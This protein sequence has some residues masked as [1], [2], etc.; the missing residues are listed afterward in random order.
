MREALTD[1]VSEVTQKLNL[2]RQARVQ[3]YK[4]SVTHL[5]RGKHQQSRITATSPRV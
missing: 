5:G 4:G 3:R 2:E 1:K